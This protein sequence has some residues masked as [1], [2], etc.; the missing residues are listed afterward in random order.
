[1]AGWFPEEAPSCQTPF[2]CLTAFFMLSVLPDIFIEFERKE[3][4]QRKI[5]DVETWIFL[6]FSCVIARAVDTKNAFTSKDMLAFLC[7]D[8]SA[9]H[10]QR[11][12]AQRRIVFTMTWYYGGCACSPID[13]ATLGTPFARAVR[14]SVRSG[15]ADTCRAW[16]SVTT[17]KIRQISPIKREGWKR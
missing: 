4:F 10:G 11:I 16:I 12:C 7:A 8:R 15:A 2:R 14:S 1:M 3:V 17:R 13:L 6:Y 9:T 5:I